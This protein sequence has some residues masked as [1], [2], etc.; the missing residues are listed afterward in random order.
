[1][2]GHKYTLLDYMRADKV[3]PWDLPNQRNLLHPLVQASLDEFTPQKWFT[4]AGA[5]NLLCLAKTEGLLADCDDYLKKMEQELAS[6]GNCS[7]NWQ[8]LAVSVVTQMA[9]FLEVVPAATYIKLHRLLVQRT[10]KNGR[11]RNPED[12]YARA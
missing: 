3:S 1:M 9:Y 12:T 2:L 5:F 10:Q 7:R 11:K 8:I 4:I 6:L